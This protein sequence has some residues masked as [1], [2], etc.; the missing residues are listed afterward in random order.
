MQQLVGELQPK[1]DVS[2]NEYNS[3]AFILFDFDIFH[4]RAYMCVYVFDFGYPKI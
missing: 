1:I 4:G 2:L 3:A